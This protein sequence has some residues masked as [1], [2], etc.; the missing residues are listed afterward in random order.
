MLHLLYIL[1]FVVI[2]FFAI[3]N[4]IRNLITLGA[5]SPPLPTSWLW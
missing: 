2:A 1:F 3:N 4:L 5:E